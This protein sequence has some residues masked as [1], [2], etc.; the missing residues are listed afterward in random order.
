MECFM[1][2]TNLCRLSLLPILSLPLYLNAADSGLNLQM[3]KPAIMV[4]GINNSKYVANEYIVRFKAGT[5]ADTISRISAEIGSQN[6]SAKQMAP[7]QLKLINGFVANINAKQLDQLTRD[8]QVSSIEVN[9][10]LSVSGATPNADSWGI[11][12]LDQ[13]NLPLDSTYA[14]YGTGNG[15]HAYVIDSGIRTT[16]ADFEGR[17]QWDFTASNINDG[18]DDGTGHGTHMAGTIAG[19]NYGVATEAQLHAVKVLDN[20]GN[21][22]LAGL[23]EGIEYVTNNHQAPAVA[24]IGM[25]VNHS[26]ALNDAI[27]ASMAAGVSYAVA[28]GDTHRRPRRSHPGRR[29]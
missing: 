21:G 18:N 23:I 15:V 4:A 29:G 9:Q 6:R 28:S 3:T 8:P 13:V 27:N 1:K 25:S 14:P 2:L 17:A 16:H 7:R 11:D 12:R 22:T 24:A 10:I 26:Q 19:G 20:S 5:N